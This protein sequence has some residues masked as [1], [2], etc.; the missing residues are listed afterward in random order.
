VWYDTDGGTIQAAKAATVFTDFKTLTGVST[1]SDFQ[2][3]MTK[4]FAA[5]QAGSVPWNFVNIDTIGDMII[6]EQKGYLA[7]LDTSIVP[8]QNLEAGTYDKYAIHAEFYGIVLAWNT[9]KWPLSGPHPTSMTDLLNTKDFPGK[10][11]MYK[12][13]QAGATFEAPLLADGVPP[14]QLYPLDTQRALTKLDSIKKDIVWWTSG[15]DSIRFLINGECD[16]GVAWNG[17]VFTAVTQNNAPL[18][19]TWNDA[20]YAPS[21]FAIPKGAPNEKTGQAMMAMWILDKAAQVNF[22]AKTAYPTQIKDLSYPTS[23]APWV[24]AGPNISNATVQDDTYYATALPSLTDQFN[25]WL[26]K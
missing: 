17:R 3:D 22:V 19:M 5:E 16:M 26:A 25:A 14:S 18:A 13:P 8:V 15:D 6:S 24:A 11:C 2:P 10:R 7:P 20:L 21:V 23:V 12:Y 1:V 4:F 9:N